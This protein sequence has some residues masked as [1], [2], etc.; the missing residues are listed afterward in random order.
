MR[1]ALNSAVKKD[2]DL[3]ADNV[4]DLGK[5]VKRAARSVELTPT[6]VGNHNS[7]AA[8]IDGPLCVLWAHHALEAKLVA[9]VLDHVGDITPTHRRV[10]HICEVIT[11]GCRAARHGNVVF[12]LR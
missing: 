9:P 3:V 11:N 2:I 8:N 5:L 12:Q 4:D 7:G 10:E 1:S 6:V